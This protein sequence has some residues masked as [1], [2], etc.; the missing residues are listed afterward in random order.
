MPGPRIAIL[1]SGG[2]APGMNAAIRAATLVGQ[3]R[4]ATV[5]GVR[6]GYRGL[7]EGDFHLLERADATTALLLREALSAE[8]RAEDETDGGDHRVGPHREAELLLRE[9]VGDERRGVGE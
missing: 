4:G 3:A 7:V 8:D 9:G 2:D 6:H 5:L 1:T